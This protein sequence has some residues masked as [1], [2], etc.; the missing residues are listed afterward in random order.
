MK[1]FIPTKGRAIR[2]RK[3]RTWDHLHDEGLEC[4]LVIEPQDVKRYEGEGDLLVM[5]E[6][7]RGIAYARQFILDQMVE[8]SWVLDDDL[9]SCGESK[10]GGIKPASFLRVLNM[11]ESD[12]FSEDVFITGPSYVQ[13]VRKHDQRHWKF[14]R[15][16]SVFY[17]IFPDAVKVPYDVDQ[18]LMQD[19]KFVMQNVLAGKVSV[20]SRHALF[21]T[22]TMNSEGGGNEEF[23]GADGLA[24]SM[25]RRFMDDV[26]FCHWVHRDNGTVRMAV[27]WRSVDAEHSYVRGPAVG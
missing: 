15:C 13:S 24:E 22:A 19:L 25:G 6:N 5:P 17:K 10:V 12:Q 11:F 14:N 23:Y 16:C 1:I 3:K 20:M 26:P 4:T 9:S 2:E 18:K 8:P 21:R 27:D 7:D